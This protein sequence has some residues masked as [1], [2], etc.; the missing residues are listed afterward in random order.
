[1]QI[2]KDTICYNNYLFL[3]SYCMY[4]IIKVHRYYLFFTLD[5]ILLRLVFGKTRIALKSVRQRSGHP[6]VLY[7]FP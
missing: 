2:F 3:S 1:M 4:D 5:E 6:P 7:F